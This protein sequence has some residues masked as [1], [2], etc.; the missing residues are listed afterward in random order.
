MYFKN[1]FNSS[2]DRS[3]C[4]SQSWLWLPYLRTTTYFF[5]FSTSR[6][7]NFMYKSINWLFKFENQIYLHCIYTIFWDLA[8]FYTQKFT[9]CIVIEK[10]SKV[11]KILHHWSYRVLCYILEL[12]RNIKKDPKGNLPNPSPN[13]HKSTLLNKTLSKEQFSTQTVKIDELY[14]DHTSTF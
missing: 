13:L 2:A 10:S 14:Y 3:Y 5:L 12:Q 8:R 1:N 11:K 4:L 7:F 6:A 9:T